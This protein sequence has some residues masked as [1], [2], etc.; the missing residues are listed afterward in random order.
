MKRIVFYSLFAH[1]HTNPTLPVVSELVKRGYEV[2]YYSTEEFK[3]K[4]EGTGAIF[5]DYNIPHYD[6]SRIPPN[7]LELLELL[8][9]LT[10]SLLPTLV[11]EV[12]EISPTCIIHDSL[13]LW[14]WII[15]KNMGIPSIDSITTFALN[16]KI[17]K[18]IANRMIIQKVFT[19]PLLLIRLLRLKKALEKRYKVR[20]GFSNIV[21]NPEKLNIVYT[22]RKF[23]PLAD[24][25]DDTYSFVGPSIIP[26]GEIGEFPIEKLKDREVIYISLGTVRNRRPDFYKNC[27][28]AFR[29]SP[30]LIIM[31][32]G[33]RID[34]KELGK[35][36]HNFLIYPHV[37]QIEIL[38]R[39]SLFITHGGM[40][41]VHEALYFGVP[42]LVFPQT[43]EQRLVGYRV[44]KTG[45]G[46]VID[47]RETTPEILRM[48]AEKLLNEP[49]YRKNA[50]KIGTSFKEAGGYKR[51]ADRIDNFC[52]EEARA[53]ITRPYMS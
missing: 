12:K 8:L 30:Y 39:A 13:S 4:I 45:A 52:K 31:S 34:I 14:G 11:R 9:R 21:L 27:I 46:E 24:E 29:E 43:S 20:F 15:G 37:P 44:E 18:K 6:I 25:F 23:Q 35:I 47:E 28:E 50:E 22:S 32:I 2:I 3:E 26:H 40:N 41:S 5:R 19:S 49:S 51:A 33:N 53:S 7:S 42:L 1:G 16:R 36:P 17:L 48:Y 10:S 38:K